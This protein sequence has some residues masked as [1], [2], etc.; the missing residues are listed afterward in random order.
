MSHRAFSDDDRAFIRAILTS[1][2][3]VSGWLVYADWLDDNDAPEPAEFLR[4]QV[5]RSQLPPKDVR[6]GAIDARL[7]ELREC[8]HRGWAAVF[9]RPMIENC[10]EHF[11]FKCPLKW[12][13]LKLTDDHK[14]RHC[15]ACNK[16]VYYCDTVVEAR[17]YA[18]EGQ[19][20]TVPLGVLRYPGDL[21]PNASV[22]GMM[23]PAPAWVYERLERG[24]PL[25]P[26]PN[27]TEPWLRELLPEPP[28]APRRPWWKFW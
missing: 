21:D 18:N 28:P 19:C 24:E 9:D 22:T 11:A 25:F 3:E 5:E 7:S 15:D 26:P 1:P 6:R 17:G 14:V 20:V 12:E 10:D 23:A 4:L 16:S 8:V 2:A 13:N 27:E